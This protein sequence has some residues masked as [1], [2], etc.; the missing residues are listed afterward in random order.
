MQI[1]HATHPQML[2]E[3]HLKTINAHVIPTTNNLEH[4]K[5]G[6]QK[7]KGPL[8]VKQFLISHYA[9]QSSGFNLSTFSCRP[10]KEQQTDDLTQRA[11]AV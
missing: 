4:P 7:E 10:S 5:K 11:T 3:Q 6:R 9:R 8:C 2:F 1:S